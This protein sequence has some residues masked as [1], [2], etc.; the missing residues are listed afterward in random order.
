MTFQSWGHTFDGAYLDPA[1]LQARGGVYVVWCK[2][3]E[4]WSVL[5]VG[6]AHDVRQRLSDHERAECWRRHCR[7]AIYYAATYTGGLQGPGRR[8]IEAAIRSVTSPP[9]GDR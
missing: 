5:D 2:T 9:C 6:E 8:Q 7:G 3:G 4:S 1:Q